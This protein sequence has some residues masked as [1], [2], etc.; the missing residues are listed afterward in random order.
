MTIEEYWKGWS[1]RRVTDVL[2]DGYRLC[3]EASEDIYHVGEA[4]IVKSACIVR[5]TMNRG[6]VKQTVDSSVRSV[7]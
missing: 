2:D 7:C 3:S 5:Y 4:G 1:V 6:F